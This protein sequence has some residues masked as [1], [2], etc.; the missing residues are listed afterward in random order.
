MH[1]Y[2][3]RLSKYCLSSIVRIVCMYNTCRAGVWISIVSRKNG[4]RGALIAGLQT[5]DHCRRLIT[6]RLI[7]ERLSTEDFTCIIIV[8]LRGQSELDV[9][10][11]WRG[12]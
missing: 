5:I 7:T 6:G 3:A 9:M 8:G 10:V 2:N 4:S 1:Q 11:H 12:T